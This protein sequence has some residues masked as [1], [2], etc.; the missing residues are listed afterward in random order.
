MSDSVKRLESLGERSDSSQSQPNDSSQFIG[1]L[2]VP[3]DARRSDSLKDS[4]QYVH[5]TNDD[6][7]PKDS[8]R[9][10]SKSYVHLNERRN[11]S[12]HNDSSRAASF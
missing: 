3:N 1:R 8:S 2:N 5:C 4:S 10:M 11:D 6:S 9:H 12:I 7:I